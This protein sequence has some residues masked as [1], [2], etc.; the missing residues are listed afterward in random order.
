MCNSVLAAHGGLECG[1]TVFERWQS[2][3]VGCKGGG[4]SRQN[5]LHVVSYM[6]LYYCRPAHLLSQNNIA[7]YVCTR[8]IRSCT[9]PFTCII[10]Q[11]FRKGHSNLQ[12][13]HKKA[14]KGEIRLKSC[15]WTDHKP[16]LQKPLSLK[17]PKPFLLPLQVFCVSTRREQE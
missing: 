2:C 3:L 12:G 1:L 13:W 10:T 11:P 14:I 15:Y 17:C 8:A 5:T 16:K 7:A 4:N 9:Q 6:I